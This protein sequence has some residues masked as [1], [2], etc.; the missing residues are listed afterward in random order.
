MRTCCLFSPVF[1]ETCLIEKTY[2]PTPPRRGTPGFRPP[3]VLMRS[4][5]QNEST[6][7]TTLIFSMLS[8][9]CD[10]TIEMDIW[11]AGVL[12][13]NLVI[14]DRNVINPSVCCCNAIFAF[15]K[16]C[17]SSLR[18]TLTHCCSG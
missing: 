3:E 6:Q 8:L 17:D 11:S 7:S 2:R 13:M 9:S 16:K 10:A 14:G 15:V 5:D 1:S 4:F 18:T 12:L